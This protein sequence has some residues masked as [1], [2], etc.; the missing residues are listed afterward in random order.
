MHDC[1]LTRQRSLRSL[2][3]QVVSTHQELRSATGLV[4]GCLQTHVCL[5]A[6]HNTVQTYYLLRE[7]IPLWKRA[8]SLL[9]QKLPLAQWH[10]CCTCVSLLL[11][12]YFVVYLQLHIQ[13]A[14]T[15]VSCLNQMHVLVDKLTPHCA[16]QQYQKWTQRGEHCKGWSQSVRLCHAFSSCTPY[17]T[18]LSC[19]LSVSK[20]AAI[21]G[22]C[23]AM[24]K[25]PWPQLKSNFCHPR[26]ILVAH[27]WNIWIFKTGNT[28]IQHRAGKG[29][30]DWTRLSNSHMLGTGNTRKI[31]SYG[32]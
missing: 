9:H 11:L 19:R 23:D 14:E 26:L 18:L 13:I 17:E 30:T 10:K 5:C 32:I 24:Y 7:I 3:S 2:E 27:F 20:Y 21:T 29:T 12:Q 31:T 25:H 8:G 1:Q 6:A 15:P 22:S 4:K 28:A 16:A